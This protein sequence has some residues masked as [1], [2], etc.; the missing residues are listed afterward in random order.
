MFS[1]AHPLGNLRQ[2]HHPTCESGAEVCCVGM[3]FVT[4]KPSVA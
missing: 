1:R 4:C 2:T 3:Y